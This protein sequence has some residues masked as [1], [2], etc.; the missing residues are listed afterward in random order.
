MSLWR[1]IN[2]IFECYTWG[3]IKLCA[4][5]CVCP[6]VYFRVLRLFGDS[7]LGS[8]ISLHIRLYVRRC[9]YAFFRL[10]II[11]RMPPKKYQPAKKET[12]LL[13]EVHV[14]TCRLL[15]PIFYWVRFIEGL[16]A[17][18]TAPSSIDVIAAHAPK[19]T[20]NMDQ[21]YLEPLWMMMVMAEN[22]FHQIM[23]KVIRSISM[24]VACAHLSYNW[25]DFHLCP[26]RP[27]GMTYVGVVGA[28]DVDAREARSDSLGAWGIHV[29]CHSSG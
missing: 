6:A 21:I 25:N 14:L 28:H 8:H 22:Y 26:S 27:N 16:N 13:W 10:S 17:C 11:G 2:I 18:C 7:V 12:F 19:T 20:R 3:W 29:V 15:N 5:V 1:N 9:D 4:C 23:P 24:Q